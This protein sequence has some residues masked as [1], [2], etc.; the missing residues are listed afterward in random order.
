MSLSAIVLT[1][2]EQKHLP[3]CLASLAW[4]DEIVVFDSFSTD[5]TE[6]I[7]RAHRAR[8]IQ[9]TFANYAAQRNAALDSLQA[10]W[11]FFVDA[12]ERIPPPLAEEVRA[13]I[14]KPEPVGWWVPRHNYLFGKLTL[15]AGWYPDYQLRLLKRGQAR[16]DTERHVHE[17]V[18]LDDV[19]GYLQNPLI[20]FNYE[21][22]SE[23]LSKQRAYTR[24]DAGILHAEGKRAKPHNFILQPIRQFFWRYI[25]LHGWRDGRH[26]LRLSLFMAYFQFM[27]Y[28]C[29]RDLNASELPENRN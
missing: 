18:R 2:N 17:L 19:T 14:Q 5:R 12:D 16:Y 28:R 23:F 10:D 7:A 26:G 3:D 21:T 4:A 20:H 11:A 22:V 8:F 25:T 29:L 13:V 6:E 24:Y 15:H 27:L 1:L 9:H